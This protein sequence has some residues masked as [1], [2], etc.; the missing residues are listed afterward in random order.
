MNCGVIIASRGSHNCGSGAEGLAGCASGV[1]RSC[2]NTTHSTPITA[3]TTA[4]AC[5]WPRQLLWRT[6]ASTIGGPKA[7]PTAPS[8]R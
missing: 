5:Q 1:S 2:T 7:P 8:I 3:A 4:I 6:I